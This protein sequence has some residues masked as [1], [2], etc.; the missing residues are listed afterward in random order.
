MDESDLP[1][2]KILDPTEVTESDPLVPLPVPKKKRGNIQNLVQTGRPKGVPNK[3]TTTV[4]EA[5]EEA[6]HRA[7][8]ADYLL[9]L[10]R[11]DP[12]AFVTILAK[13]IPA[14]LAVEGGIRVEHLFTAEQ[15]RRMADAQEASHED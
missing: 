13:I 3:L 1:P 6:F 4:K 8:G 5:I 10:S 14:T 9:E 15:L 7:G 12:R 11:R 2:L